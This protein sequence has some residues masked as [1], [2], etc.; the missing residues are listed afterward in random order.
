MGEGG[1]SKK[2]LKGRRTRGGGEKVFQM[3][4]HM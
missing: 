1:R 4:C 2:A 3:F